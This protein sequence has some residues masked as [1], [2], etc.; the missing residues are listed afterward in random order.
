MGQSIDNLRTVMQYIFLKNMRFFEKQFPELFE[1]FRQ[2]KPQG[3]GL[4]LDAQGRL[5]MMNHKGALYPLSVEN[6]DLSSLCAMQMRKFFKEPFSVVFRMNAEQL[7]GAYFE[8][9]KMLKKIVDLGDDCLQQAKQS[10]ESTQTYPKMPCFMVFGVG[11][12]LHLDQIYERLDDI[13]HLVIYE[14]NLDF[15][16]ASLHL[17]DY[18]RLCKEFVKPNKSFSLFVGIDRYALFNKLYRLL[19]KVGIYKSSILYVFKHY[20]TPEINEDFKYITGKM[21]VIHTG[22]GFF[23]DEIIS[24]RNYD[25][26][27]RLSNNFLSST[28]HQPISLPVFI[29]ANGPSIDQS[30][31]FIKENRDKVFLISCGTVLGVL[32]KNEI[33]PD[34]H[35]E[36][37]RTDGPAQ[38]MQ[39]WDPDCTYT[40]KIRLVGNNTLAPAL[41]NRFKSVTFFL[42]PNDYSSEMMIGLSDGDHQRFLHLFF[43]NPTV[44]N[45]ALSFAIYYQAKEI[46]CFGTDLGFKDTDYHHSK[47]SVYYS[48]KMHYDGADK[49]ASIIREGNFG[50]EVKTDLI[51]NWSREIA[52]ELLR[53]HQDDCVV[54]NTSDGVKIEGTQPMRIADICFGTHDADFDREHW[55]EN[56]TEK[57][58]IS[59]SA[60]RKRSRKCMLKVL[61]VLDYC[62][63]PNYLKFNFDDS[64]ILDFLMRNHL[65]I[66]GLQKTPSFHPV[67]RMTEGSTLYLSALILGFLKVIEKPSARL[68]F[69]RKVVPLYVEYFSKMK[70]IAEGFI[71]KME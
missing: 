17:V 27:S 66:K 35:I 2:Y 52:E 1:K 39:L 64:N 44:F 13:H 19:Y 24:A 21:S 59:A 45:G 10:D 63:N 32:C 50:G 7:Q 62:S 69:I 51:Y 37:E 68:C 60:Y 48:G 23:E 9:L 53:R 18:E 61:D 26:N 29:C 70:K 22:F 8:H 56:N 25:L 31:D 36:I 12:G 49:G 42:K 28:V 11:V 16:Y 38:A 20:N 15:F 57:F 54:Y 40:K 67:I 14:P 55:L 71:K 5:N 3:A 43:S 30:I 6:P 33:F 46:Y 34:V 4:A 65:Y 47:D 41:L 58:V